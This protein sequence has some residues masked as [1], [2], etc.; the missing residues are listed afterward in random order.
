VQAEESIDIAGTLEPTKNNSSIVV[1]CQDV[2]TLQGAAN[3]TA[4]QLLIHAYTGI[5]ST[6]DGN[7]VINSL[8]P[9]SCLLNENPNKSLF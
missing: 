4:N 1:D 9:Q 6:G 7:A 3:L 5:E 8:E 2:L